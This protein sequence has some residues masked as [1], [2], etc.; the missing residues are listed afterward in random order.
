MPWLMLRL[1][2]FQLGGVSMGSFVELKVN[3][4]YGNDF[5]GSRNAKYYEATR[6][7]EYE[8][9]PECDEDDELIDEEE[10]EDSV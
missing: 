1:F 6:K 7:I 4:Y 9:E 10:D 8:P 5:C 3:E 2:L